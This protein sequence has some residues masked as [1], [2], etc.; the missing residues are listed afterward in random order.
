MKRAKYGNKIVILDGMTFHSKGEAD[1]WC[2]LKLLEKAGEISELERQI[3]Y[4]LYVPHCETGEPELI[5]TYVADYCY[6]ENGAL[7]VED[8]KGVRT[9]DYI[10][11]AKL[12]WACYGI[13]VRET[14][15]PGR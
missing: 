10:I 7:I 14:R 15:S 3:P 9:P 8:F 5:C 12:M 6:R 4:S 13:K 1:R 2:I 11:K